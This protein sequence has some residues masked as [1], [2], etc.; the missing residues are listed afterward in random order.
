M[1]ISRNLANSVLPRSGIM[2]PD[3]SFG[4]GSST[5]SGG[6]FAF[7]SPQMLDWNVNAPVI[8]SNLQSQVAPVHSA[9]PSQMASSEGLQ[10]GMNAETH[11]QM[12]NSEES[13]QQ[14]DPIPWDFSFPDLVFPELT[15]E[16]GKTFVG[17]ISS[18]YFTGSPWICLEQ[19]DYLCE[20]YLEHS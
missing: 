2:N 16:E 14:L 18:R 4:P 10:I 19:M 15:N 1:V 13:L 9:F 3:T 12:G 6:Q 20:I 7:A 5:A 8:N 11:G 17:A